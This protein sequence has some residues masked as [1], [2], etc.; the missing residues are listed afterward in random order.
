MLQLQQRSGKAV[1]LRGRYYSAVCLFLLGCNTELALTT[2]EIT[3]VGSGV[4]RGQ[5][6]VQVNHVAFYLFFSK[7]YLTYSITFSG[8]ILTLSTLPTQSLIKAFA[9]Q[10]LLST[11]NPDSF[12]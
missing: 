4:G 6:V 7:H 5:K 11:E 12:R 10:S 8:N 3:N 9:H 2:L 1:L